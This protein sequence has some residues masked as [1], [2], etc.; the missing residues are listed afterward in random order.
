MRELRTSQTGFGNQLL[1]QNIYSPLHSVKIYFS[2]TIYCV[3]LGDC[4]FKKQSF[5][6][7]VSDTS[8]FSETPFENI[9]GYLIWNKHFLLVCKPAFL[10]VIF[11]SL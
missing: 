5:N 1:L 6:K 8:H 4:S 9:H 11:P 3:I 2:I 7:G 10:I